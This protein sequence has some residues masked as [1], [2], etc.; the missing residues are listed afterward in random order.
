MDHPRPTPLLC[1]ALQGARDLAVV[2]RPPPSM[3]GFHQCLIPFIDSIIEFAVPQAPFRAQ[4]RVKPS[5]VA[6][7]RASAGD[8]PPPAA[9]R[10][11]KPTKPWPS[12]LHPTAQ[13]HPAV[14]QIKLIP[15]SSANFAEKP[16]HFC[17]I[18]P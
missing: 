3:A 18:N 12:D 16:L 1:F 7:D 13:N 14:G 10:Q 17:E 8:A 11:P 4:P 2:P 15:V 9:G 6:R 5:P